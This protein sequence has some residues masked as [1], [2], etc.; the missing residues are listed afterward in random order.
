MISVIE[1]GLHVYTTA[2]ENITEAYREMLNNVNIEVMI[3]WVYKLLRTNDAG[4][5]NVTD[6]NIQDLRKLDLVCHIKC[7]SVVGSQQRSF[8]HPKFRNILTMRSSNDKA[9]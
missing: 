4:Q 6:L 2:F 5:I 3:M 9:Q 7:Y 8:W 1:M